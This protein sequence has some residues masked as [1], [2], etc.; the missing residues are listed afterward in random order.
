MG[1]TGSGKTA[2]IAT[3]PGKTFAYLFDRAPCQP[4]EDLTLRYEQF[5][6][7]KVKLVAQ[8]LAKGKGD[9]PQSRIED[10]S[11]V[12]RLWEK[13]FEDRVA[14]KYWDTIDNIAFDS[15][16]TFGDIVMDRI[17]HLNGRSGHFPQGLLPCTDASHYKR[18]AYLNR[19]EQSPYVYCP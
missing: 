12:Y 7:T 15:F 8:A 4:S 14:S 9:Q 5:S 1:S 18:G 17:L 13:D 16:T 10:A 6:P 19:Y 3:L 2:Q 11:E